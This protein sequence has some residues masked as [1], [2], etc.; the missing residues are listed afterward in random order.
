MSRTGTLALHPVLLRPCG[1][2]NAAA[3]CR[4]A[5]ERELQSALGMLASREGQPPES[6]GVPDEASACAAVPAS[7]AER[8]TPPGSAAPLTFEQLQSGAA[9][10]SVGLARIS[11]LEQGDSQD[12]MQELLASHPLAP[13]RLRAQALQAWAALEGGSSRAASEVAGSPCSSS[14]GRPGSAAS[15]SFSACRPAPGSIR[16]QPLVAMRGSCG[17]GS[18]PKASQRRCTSADRISGPACGIMLGHGAQQGDCTGTQEDNQ[19]EPGCCMDAPESSCGRAAAAAHATAR[20]AGCPCATP[21]AVGPLKQ[22]WSAEEDAWVAHAQWMA[23][24]AGG[25]GGRRAARHLLALLMPQR[26]PTELVARWRWCAHTA[27]ESCGDGAQH[28]DTKHPMGCS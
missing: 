20:T 8:S 11:C 27:R 23:G 26:G 12:A 18:N 19:A 14:A 25:A 5:A 1:H 24:H 4:G 3:W 28:L 6:P 21:G 15:S 13:A 22:A 2:V 17:Y 16:G 9:R 7:T 10:L